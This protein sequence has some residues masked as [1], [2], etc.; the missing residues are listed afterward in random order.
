MAAELARASSEITTPFS[1]AIFAANNICAELGV[2][3]PLLPAVSPSDFLGACCSRN[4][5]Q[6]DP[7]VASRRLDALLTR[8][9]VGKSFHRRRWWAS[10]CPCRRRTRRRAKAVNRQ[11]YPA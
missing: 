7:D 9:A 2:L 4:A 1:C 10:L 3:R 5:R 8:D 6:M 11:A